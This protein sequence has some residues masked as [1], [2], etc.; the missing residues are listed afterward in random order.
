VNT[1]RPLL[2]ALVLAP[3]TLCATELD[4][5]FGT[6]GRVVLDDGVSRQSYD[7]ILQHDGKIVVV[8]IS[9]AGSSPNATTRDATRDVVVARFNTNGT[10]D[11]T[12]DSDGL[13]TI[14]FRGGTDDR[15]YAIAE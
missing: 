6:G 12:F 9:P 5:T 10:L 4:S 14:D 15:G 7:A 3:V 1:L 13:V 2:A 11:T 8:G